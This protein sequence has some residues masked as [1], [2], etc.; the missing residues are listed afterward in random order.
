M[1]KTSYQ[2]VRSS[3]RAQARAIASAAGGAILALAAGGA[4]PR[5]ARAAAP[6]A[7]PSPAVF[8]LSGRKD[9]L[10]H[11]ASCHGLD[12]KGGGPMA[13]ILTVKPAN[14]TTLSKRNGGVF[15]DKRVFAVIEGTDAVAAHGTREMP[16]WGPV[17]EVQST[18]AYDRAQTRIEVGER[19]RRLADYLKSIQ[20]K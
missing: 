5:I 10:F 17:F 4:T 14:L 20:R 15:P 19:I 3:V 13:D 1:S 9:Y 7:T 6:G 11:C 2:A 12:G 18:N 8:V 16:V